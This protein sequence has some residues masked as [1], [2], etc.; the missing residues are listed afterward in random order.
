MSS[1]KT[2]IKMKAFIR[3]SKTLFPTTEPNWIYGAMSYSDLY[4]WWLQR[5]NTQ[6]TAWWNIQ[7]LIGVLDFILI[8]MLE[9]E[10]AICDNWWT[11]S[12]VNLQ[13]LEMKSALSISFGAGINGIKEKH[14]LYFCIKQSWL[15][16][17]LV[18]S[19]NF[20]SRFIY[21]WIWGNSI[22]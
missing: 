16:T 8:V 19:K 5:N 7:C 4:I 15:L 3:N 11:V 2:D 22:T 12:W 21:L 20:E 17:V 14:L 18:S 6:S 9:L 10:G 13:Y 1:L